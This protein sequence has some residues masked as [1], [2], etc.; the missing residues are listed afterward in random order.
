MPR[1]VI[2]F[3]KGRSHEELWNALRDQ[4]QQEYRLVSIDRKGIDSKPQEDAETVVHILEEL[5]W[6]D[7]VLIAHGEDCRFARDLAMLAPQRV[8][9]LFLVDAPDDVTVQS[10]RHPFLHVT[11]ADSGRQDPFV[12][13]NSALLPEVF[14]AFCTLRLR[15]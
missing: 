12:L 2:H 7:A 10:T 14:H 9:A 6:P 4:F 3:Q 13:E 15:G 11:T 1:R 8:S 5:Q